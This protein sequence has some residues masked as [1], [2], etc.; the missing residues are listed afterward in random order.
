MDRP[1]PT[2]LTHALVTRLAFA[3]ARAAGVEVAHDGQ[4]HRLEARL[5]VVLSPGAIHTPKGLLQSGIGDQA[6]L[7]RLGI[8]L[9]RHLPGVGQNFQ[10]HLGF[11]CVWEYQRPLPPRNNLGEATF[12]WKSAAGLESPDLQTAQVEVPFASAENA[13]RFGFPESGWSLFAGV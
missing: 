2:V 1:N 5:E 7:Q 9:V 6:E 13:A 3:G 10:D 12:F 8:P 11:G 4:M